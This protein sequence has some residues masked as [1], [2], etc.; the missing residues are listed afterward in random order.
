MS[1][2]SSLGICRPWF[3]SAEHVCHPVSVSLRSL[4]QAELDKKRKS[5]VQ[6]FLD[7]DDHQNHLESWLNIQISRPCLFSPP[8]SLEGGP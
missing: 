1:I 8:E 2:T 4:L 6:Q 7:L 3:S 5:L